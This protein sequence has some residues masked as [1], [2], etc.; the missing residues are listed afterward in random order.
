VLLLLLPFW[1]VVLAAPLLLLA[2]PLFLTLVLALLL[3]LELVFAPLP[4]LPVEA[5]C[6]PELLTEV[7]VVAP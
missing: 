3:W 2:V 6:P 1:P 4:A 5:L 7:L